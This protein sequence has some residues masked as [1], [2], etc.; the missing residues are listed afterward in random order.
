MN[1]KYWKAIERIEDKRAI[2]TL[3]SEL[4]QSKK[5]IGTDFLSN[6]N[7]KYNGEIFDLIEEVIKEYLYQDLFII[8]RKNKKVIDKNSKLELIF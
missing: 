2:L 7:E 4:R 1:K 6:F 3:L 8:D 5:S